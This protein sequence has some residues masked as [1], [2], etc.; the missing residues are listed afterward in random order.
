VPRVLYCLPKLLAAHK[1]SLIF[2]PEGE[3]D[4]DRIVNL[5][6]AAT[7]SPSGAGKWHLIKNL[8]PLR[9]RQ[10]VILPDNDEPGR[11]HA[12]QVAQSLHQIAASVKVLELPG[13][14]SN[15]D[16]SD[17]LEQGHTKEEL[18]KLA[19]GTPEWVPTPEK[20][21]QA[22]SL[23]LVPLDDL[24][25]EPEEEVA[26]VWSQTLPAGGLSVLAAKPKVGKST[27]ARNLALAVAQG[28]DF[29]NRTTTQ[30]SVVYL[31][32]EE[33][34]SE[35]QRHFQKMGATGAESILVHFG[36]A[37]EDA[38]R[39]IACGTVHPKES[40]LRSYGRLC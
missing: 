26:W 31:A 10:V 39:A 28:Q 38:L 36:A 1:D 27:L 16:I 22:H 33:K 8:A 25:Q 18:L 12:Q 20:D 2:I 40:L 21:R 34:R 17:W 15:G 32:L 3:K 7:T 6:L 9:G 35:V 11:H 4:V 29:L 14:T 19:E 24:L 37:P 13:L 23:Q 30:G 5:G